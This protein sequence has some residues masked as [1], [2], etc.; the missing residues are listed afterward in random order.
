MGPRWMTDEKEAK[1]GTFITKKCVKIRNM[2]TAYSIYKWE[3]L[4]DKK[5]DATC[6]MQRA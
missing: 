2:Q 5:H 4:H 1:N 3:N 6:N